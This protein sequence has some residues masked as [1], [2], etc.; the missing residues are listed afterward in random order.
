M[1]NLNFT[2]DQ[3]DGLNVWIK[4]TLQDEL[5]GAE[6]SKLENVL[7]HSHFNVALNYLE[8]KIS[9]MLKD[10]ASGF[11]T[12]EVEAIKALIEK[13]KEILLEQADGLSADDIREICQV[14]QAKVPGGN[15]ND[16]SDE[17][18]SENNAIAI[19][20]FF[21]TGK[22][23]RAIKEWLDSSTNE[24]ENDLLEK[25]TTTLKKGLEAA[26]ALLVLV[27]VGGHHLNR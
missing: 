2:I 25:I 4:Q 6:F 8:N 19:M 5:T 7:E 18:S 23:F 16:E 11:F 27:S 1:A 12:D 9:T 15:C 10:E 14:E 3:D 21:L 17:E 13:S 26:I 22:E 24:I 20:K